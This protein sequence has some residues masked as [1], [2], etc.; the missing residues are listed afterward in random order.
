MY[1]SEP[2]LCCQ[3]EDLDQCCAR[4]G[5]GSASQ[6]RTTCG[7][8]NLGAACCAPTTTTTVVHACLPGRLLLLL[9]RSDN[10]PQL[11]SWGGGLCQLVP[12]CWQE[13]LPGL[14]P[15]HRNNATTEVECNKTVLKW[16]HCS[17]ASSGLLPASCRPHRTKGLTHQ[18]WHPAA[19]PAQAKRRTVAPRGVQANPPCFCLPRC[20]PCCC[21][22][23]VSV[24]ACWCMTVGQAPVHRNP[25]TQPCPCSTC[26]AAHCTGR[27]ALAMQ[28]PGRFSFHP[29][30]SYTQPKVCTPKDG[31]R[32]TRTCHKGKASCN[33]AAPY[34]K[35]FQHLATSEPCPWQR[36][37][38]CVAQHRTCT[39]AAQN[40]Q[41]PPACSCANTGEGLGLGPDAASDPQSHPWCPK[42]THASPHHKHCAKVRTQHSWP[43]GHPKLLR[44]HGL[45]LLKR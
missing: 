45:W 1:P 24:C 35:P 4:R 15:L 27:C 7:A 41:R 44:L 10:L 14:S 11:V 2:H 40:W 43:A 25:H 33:Q 3:P 36:R 31:W 9:F 28:H 21:Y 30:P 32:C 39:P 17:A 34:N 20:P 42:H 23:R 38:C 12:S 13:A 5:V 16:Q 18:C 22:P 6:P 29:Q 26:I 8:P 19:H 37:W